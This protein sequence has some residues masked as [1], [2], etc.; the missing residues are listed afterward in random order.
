MARTRDVLLAMICV[1]FFMVVGASQL[2]LVSHGPG[3][4]TEIIETASVETQEVIVPTEKADRESRIAMWQERLRGFT[5]KESRIEE[6]TVAAPDTPSS[7]EVPI[8][9]ACSQ[10]Q[11]YTGL[12]PRLYNFEAEGVRIFSS[13]DDILLIDGAN[14]F[15]VLPIRIGQSAVG[16]NCLPT[17]VVGVAVNGSLLRNDQYETYSIFESETLVGYALDGFPIYGRLD[18]SQLDRCGGRMT[19]NGYQYHIAIDRQSIIQC[20]GAPPAVLP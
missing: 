1:G 14:T 4:D 12:P 13:S 8:A 5:F 19:P 17:D 11:R 10:F 2:G 16:Q 15:V 7:S 9:M 20:F 3:V 6:I 18:S